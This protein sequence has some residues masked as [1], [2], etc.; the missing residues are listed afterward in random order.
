M[1]GSSTAAPQSPLEL[2]DF[3][4]GKQCWAQEPS[5]K[6]HSRPGSQG[7]DIAGLTLIQSFPYLNSDLFVVNLPPN[8]AFLFLALIS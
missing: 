3:G 6:E 1:T 8:I 4:L 7:N 2:T 5:W